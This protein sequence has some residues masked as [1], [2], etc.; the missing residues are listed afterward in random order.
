M[1]ACCENGEDKTQFSDRIE[2]ADY[3]SLGV[4]VL[5]GAL[6]NQHR[7]RFLDYAFL[8]SNSPEIEELRVFTY[9]VVTASVQQDVASRLADADL[10]PDVQVHAMSKTD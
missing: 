9:P 7:G 4:Y 1:W 5:P 6:Y 10:R 3:P 8:P 2:Q